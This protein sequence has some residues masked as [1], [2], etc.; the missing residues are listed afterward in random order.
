MT[1]VDCRLQPIEVLGKWRFARRRSK[2]V[3]VPTVEITLHETHSFFS[4]AGAQSNA[5]GYPRFSSSYFEI[6]IY[7]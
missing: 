6:P 1:V 2:V 4:E 3:V 7:K 5:H